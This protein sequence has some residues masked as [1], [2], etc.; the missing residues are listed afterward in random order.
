MRLTF[1]IFLSLILSVAPA[2]AQSVTDNLPPAIYQGNAPT[3]AQSK[4]VSAISVEGYTVTGVD[5]DV[6]ADSA[7][8]AR[9]QALMLA[10]RA[11][12][13]QLCKRLGVAD[14]SDKLDNDTLAALVQ[15]FEIQ[16]E[17]LSAVRYIGVYT[18]HFN[19]AAIQRIMGTQVAP[20]APVSEPKTTPQGPV[21]HITVDVQVD[22]LAT[23][24][25]IKQ[26][27]SVTPRVVKV[28]TLTLGRGFVRIDLSYNGE[29]GSLVQAVTD[30]GLIL[31]QSGND[32]FDL[33]DGTVEEQ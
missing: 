33:F 31:S 22:T 13:V 23:W 32:T 10:E 30:R 24:A 15:S 3:S 29:L 8:H 14:N 16:R 20:V 19:P 1:I 12:Y 5:A 28:D 2:Q 26:R 17:R 11:A 18:V 25:Q 21:S 6:T 7:A 4:P 27:L 9:D